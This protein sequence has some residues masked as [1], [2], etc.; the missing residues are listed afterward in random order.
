L[1]FTL[2]QRQRLGRRRNVRGRQY[3][4]RIELGRLWLA[5]Q[6]WRGIPV[7]G[8]L[9]GIEDLTRNFDLRSGG[10]MEFGGGKRLWFGGRENLVDAIGDAQQQDRDNC[11]FERVHFSPP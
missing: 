2:G 4:R 8:L 11:I 9:R 3:R 10:S 5:C 1:S 6:D 7:I